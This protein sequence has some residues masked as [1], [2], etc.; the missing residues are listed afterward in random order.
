MRVPI[1]GGPSEFVLTAHVP[2]YLNCTKPPANLCTIWE[3]DYDHKQVSFTA[4]DPLRGRGREL[5]R[6]DTDSNKFYTLDLSPDG[7]RIAYA[8]NHEGPVH[9][10]SLRG[11]PSQE[12]RVK[13][14]SNLQD[15]EW[16]GAE[17]LLISNR[18]RTLDALDVLLHVDMQGNARVLWQQQGGF[19]GYIGQLSPDGRH[20]TFN[21][22]GMNSNI[23]MMENF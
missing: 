19:G 1:T 20:L 21:G 6:I 14:W 11:E 3:E 8:N 7:T 16:A 5:G 10:L 23:W 13:G 2:G 22:F 12:I 15:I 9:I 4:F 17:A 18:V